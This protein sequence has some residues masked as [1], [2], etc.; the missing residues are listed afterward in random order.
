M[1]R[2]Y[3]DV[4]YFCL[5]RY[6]LFNYIQLHFCVEKCCDL[7]YFSFH[8]VSPLALMDILFFK[9]VFYIVHNRCFGL[10]LFIYLFLIIDTNGINN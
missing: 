8:T 4:L 3:S 1:E 6:I 10:Y 5:Y 2:L 9:W 7:K